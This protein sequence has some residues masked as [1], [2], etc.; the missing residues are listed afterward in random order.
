MKDV[1]NVTGRMGEGEAMGPMEEAAGVAAA[2]EEVRAIALTDQTGSDAIDH[3]QA[4]AASEDLPKA[5][6]PDPWTGLLQ[7][8]AEL[9]SALT[10]ADDGKATHPW[11]ARDRA[12]GARSLKVPLPPPETVQRLADALAAFSDALRHSK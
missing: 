5:A 10:A 3:P 2:P 8:G 9:V 12:T 6:R 4:A 7:M 11:V 1:E